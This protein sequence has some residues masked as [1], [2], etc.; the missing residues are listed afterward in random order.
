[1]CIPIIGF[2]QGFIDAVVKVFVVGKDNVSS[3]IV[4]LEMNLAIA[5][6][7]WKHIDVRSPR[8]SHRWKLNHQESRSSR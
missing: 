6:Y 3:D 7:I 8:A 5:V 1:M 4:E 2:G